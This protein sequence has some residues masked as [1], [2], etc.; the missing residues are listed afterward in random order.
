MF[1]LSREYIKTRCKGFA[2][3]KLVLYYVY[4]ILDTQFRLEFKSKRRFNIK[5][6]W[7]EVCS[8]QDLILFLKNTVNFFLTQTI[9]FFSL[10]ILVFILF[11]PAFKAESHFIEKTT[12]NFEK[13][14][15]WMSPAYAYSTKHSRFTTLPFKH[16]SDL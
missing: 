16:L 4:Q 3:Y 11:V 10:Y 8:L 13:E 6:L 2:Y 7:S 15:A 1:K 9:A 12:I 14:D 5:L